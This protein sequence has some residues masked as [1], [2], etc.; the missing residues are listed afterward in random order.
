MVYIQQW[1]TAYVLAWMVVYW[2]TECIPP[3]VTGMLPVVVLP[4]AGVASLSSL[5][6]VYWNV[7]T[8]QL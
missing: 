3:A 8:Q 7:R 6:P 1:W 4:L 5:S 2:V